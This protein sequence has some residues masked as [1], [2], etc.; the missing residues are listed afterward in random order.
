MTKK[1]WTK[2]SLLA[3]TA[4]LLLPVGPTWASDNGT[5]LSAS[6]SVHT[7]SDSTNKQKAPTYQE[8]SVHDPSVI[9]V[10]DEFYIFGSHL[11]SAKSSDLM[12][13]QMISSGVANGNPLIP[14]VKEELK[15]TF[16]WAQSDTL[17]AA[18]VI[19]LADGKFYMY[20]NACKGDSPRSA[21]GVAVSDNIEGPYKDQGIFLKSGMWGEVGAGGTIYDA[22]KDPNAVDPDTFFDKEGKLWMVYGSYSG[23]IFILQLDPLSGKPLPDQGYGKKLIGGNHS[24]IEGP[25]MLYSPQTD[26]YYLFLSFG[27]L[28]SFGGYN[29][30]IARSHNPD[31]PFY[32]AQGNDMTNVQADPTKPL[33]DDASIAPYGV[34][35]MGNYQFEREIGDPGQGVGANAVSPGH[36]SAYYDEKTGK[37]FLIFHSRFV[38]RGEEHEVRVHEMFMNDKGWPVV[39]PYRYAG[40]HNTASTVKAKDIAGEY[41]WITQDK[42]ISANVHPSVSVEL[43]ENGNITGAVQGTWTL[44]GDHNVQ[45][46]SNGVEYNGVFLH[47]T[48]PQSG[49]TTLTLTALSESGVGVWGSQMEPRKDKQ[50]VSAV[51]KDL[52]LGDISAVFYPLDLPAKGTHNTQIT[53]KSS[54]PDIISDKGVVKRPEAGKGNA[55]V[56]MIATITKGDAKKNKNF[57]VTV[58]EQGRGPLLGQYDFNQ[59]SGTTVQDNTYNHYDGTLHSGASWS[60]A[61]RQGGAVALNGTDGYVQLPGTVT[62]GQDFTFAGWVNWQGGAAWQRILDFGDG[63]N[64]FMFLT[65]SQ[66]KGMQFTIHQQNTDQNLITSTPLPLNKWVHVAVTMEGNTGKLYVDGKL[67]ATN[68][69]MTFNPSDLMTRE[70]YLGKSRFAADAYFKGL[71]D[72]VRIYNKALSEVEIQALSK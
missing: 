37:Y 55:K 40:E 46:N 67:S 51:D 58:L 36:N 44:Q 54:K 34:K 19:Q 12:N 50:F 65:P 43:Q 17:W 26:Y 71:L 6:E 41:Q 52:D 33:F 47:E 11:A 64:S 45:I 15:E 69:K 22:T 38:D 62:D 29:V 24:R 53:W 39:A 2:T 60:T 56:T 8:A 7:A 16:D 20:Y 32:D 1:M 63:M 68:E 18:D 9:R 14:N 21:L 30:R 25:Y 72:E 59:T 3:L 10:G 5:N 35:I 48:N 23:G 4:A 13:W 28:D 31:G 42:E 49:D 57:K 27:G 70:A 61:G 66:G